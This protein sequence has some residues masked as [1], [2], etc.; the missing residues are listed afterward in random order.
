ME[1][2]TITAIVR[3]KF[4]FKLQFKLKTMVFSVLLDTGEQL[5]VERL[6]YGRGDL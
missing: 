4:I 2:G 3:W 1:R 6:R 5:E